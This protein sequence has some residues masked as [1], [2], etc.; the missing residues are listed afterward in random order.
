ML[1]AATSTIQRNEFSMRLREARRGN[2]DSV[3]DVSIF[4]RP[5]NPL[6]SACSLSHWRRVPFLGDNI[7]CQITMS[8]KPGQII[9][10]G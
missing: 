5:F 1:A 4:C 10:N 9:E 3:F 6:E 7:I 2:V 8:A